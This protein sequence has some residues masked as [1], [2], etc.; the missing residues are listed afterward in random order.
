MEQTAVERIHSIGK[1][2]LEPKLRKQ[3]MEGFIRGLL[4][5]QDLGPQRF[6]LAFECY[7]AKQKYFPSDEKARQYIRTYSSDHL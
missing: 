7:L 1:S 3:Q 6:D 5:D 4:K 2:D